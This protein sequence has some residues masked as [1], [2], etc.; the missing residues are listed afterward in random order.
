[1]RRNGSQ[2]EKS[3]KRNYIRPRVT[4]DLLNIRVIICAQLAHPP[5]SVCK[6]TAE[7]MYCI[8]L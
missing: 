3:G 5:L 8:F 6:Y 4:N 7:N 1:M 2:S